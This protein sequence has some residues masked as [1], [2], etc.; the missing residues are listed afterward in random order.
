MTRNE[1]LDAIN[2]KIART[3]HT[4]YSNIRT[5]YYLPVMIGDILH[6]M[7]RFCFWDDDFKSYD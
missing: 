4:E 3:A 6:Y 5:N 1:M 2:I 7:D